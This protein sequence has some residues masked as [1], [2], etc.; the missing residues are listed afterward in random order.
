MKNI[1][2]IQLAIQQKLEIQLRD[3]Y[4]MHKLQSVQ[5]DETDSIQSLEQMLIDEIKM[6]SLTLTRHL[7]RNEHTTKEL[8][9]LEMEQEQLQSSNAS[10]QYTLST[11]QSSVLSARQQ[12]QSLVEKTSH[13][14]KNLKPFKLNMTCWSIKGRLEENVDR[15]AQAV[16]FLK[17]KQTLC[18]EKPNIC[19]KT[20]TVF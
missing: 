20:L 17:R 15:T 10:Q 1:T 8:I 9:R 6:R 18:N 4:Q 19:N 5:T 2:E 11:L 13:L 7:A 12:Q 14:K 16:N 3:L